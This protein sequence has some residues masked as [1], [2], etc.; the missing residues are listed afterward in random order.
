MLLGFESIFHA[1][2]KCSFLQKNLIKLPRRMKMVLLESKIPKTPKQGEGK[3]Y[4]QGSY[5][6]DGSP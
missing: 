2:Q 6:Q 1:M 4:P 3:K 5:P